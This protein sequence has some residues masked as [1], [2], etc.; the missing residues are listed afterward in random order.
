MEAAHRTI[1][2]LGAG[3]LGAAVGADLAGHGHE[4]KAS[5]TSA[6]KVAALRARGM[7][8]FRLSVNSQGFSADPKPFLQSHTLLIALPPTGTDN[9]AATMQTIV[10]ALAATPVRR[11]IFTSSTSV[12]PDTGGIV[13]EAMV[14]QPA[15]AMNQAIAEAEQVLQASGWPT[16]VLRCGG[17]MGYGRIPG[18]YT[19]G[20]TGVA[21]GQARVNLVY[22]DDVVRLIRRLL[23]KGPTEGVFNVVADQHPRRAELYAHTAARHGFAPTQFDP[24]S[25]AT[26]KIVS[27]QKLWRELAFAFAYPDPA[28]F[29]YVSA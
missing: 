23:A 16:V 17:L 12:Y 21:N 3:W 9:Y 5:T 11:L 1:S 14:A 13:T 26:F 25:G 7:A 28:R 19:A 20:Q 2:I 15:D 22:R 6:S 18:R 8:P 24:A 4:V 29:P 10:T 27:N